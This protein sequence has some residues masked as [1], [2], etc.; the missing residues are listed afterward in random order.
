MFHALRKRFSLQFGAAALAALACG[1]SAAAPA[2][3]P[4]TPA[5]WRDA[6]HADIEAAVRIT[7]E[8]HPGVLDARN[9][10]F[11]A[12]L[13]AARR[14][15][16]ALAGQVT[17][18]RSYTAA[19]EGFNVRIK[20][21]HAGMFARLGDAKAAQLRWP[22]FVTVWRG[23]GLY[24]HSAQPGQ[25]AVGSRLRSC[26]GKA[27]GQLIRDNVFSFQG[28][29][30]E[31]GQWWSRARRVFLDDGNPFI[32]LPRRCRFESKGRVQ[33]H[34]LA[35]RAIDA[36]GERWLDDSNGGDAGPVG[37]SEPRKNLF[38]VS[39]PTFHPNEAERAAYRAMT[40]E[41]EAQRAR[42]LSLD[43][44]VVDL[45]KNQGGSSSWSQGFAEALWGKERVRKESA[46]YDAGVEVWWRAS[47]DNTSYVAS[48]AER[49]A[50]EGSTEVAARIAVY[51]QGM[52][53]ALAA[54]K[55][56]YVEPEDPA[57]DAA[58]TPDGPAFTRPVYVI[59]PGNCASACLDALDVFTRF[60]NTVLVGAPSSADSTYMDVR[61]AEL[62]SGRA[63]VI[64]PNKVY[65]NRKRANGEIYK[66]QIEVRDVAWTGA[67]LLKAVEADLARR[68]AGGRTAGR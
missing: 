63:A 34:V 46:A 1:L 7:R 66:P 4:A 44:V 29:V 11:A 42:W 67:T 49:L 30:D 55:P 19:V 47:P 62:E 35:W 50:R 21:G 6:A 13:E 28:R 22:G 38:W 39:M 12:N 43:A 3:L 23:D 33:E 26:D 14:H 31:A 25:P 9:P 27:A 15:G 60:P 18:A 20:D 10:G 65:V 5:A 24:V 48:L 64:V 2:A 36:E 51:A 41:L 57:P 53:D 17:D 61:V 68:A 8:N 40:A 45:R 32:A 16:L 54:G 58:A 59:V 56:F 37:V 52:R